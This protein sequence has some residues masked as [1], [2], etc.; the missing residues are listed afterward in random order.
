MVVDS[1]LNWDLVP[2]WLE[3][4]YVF[5]EWD[6]QSQSASQDRHQ[7]W[8]LFINRA[9]APLC[10]GY[11]VAILCQEKSITSL[12]LNYTLFYILRLY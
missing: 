8:E 1:N 3:H 5:Y 12:F 9:R 2:A 10:N 4:T 11:T 6:S 7:T